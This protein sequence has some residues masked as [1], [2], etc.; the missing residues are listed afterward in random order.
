MKFIVI[1]LTICR[2]QVRCYSRQQG[3]L[4][5]GSSRKR[6]S[7]AEILLVRID[8]QTISGGKSENVF[9]GVS[10]FLLRVPLRGLQLMHDSQ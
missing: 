5:A 9:H 6:S 10:L 4:N 3:P 2:E 1:F 7:P 8:V